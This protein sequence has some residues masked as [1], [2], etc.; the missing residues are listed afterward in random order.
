[1]RKLCEPGDSANQK[2][3][4]LLISGSYDESHVRHPRSIADSG[5]QVN[6]EHF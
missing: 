1:M 4:S 3:S 5:F 6:I 2:Q